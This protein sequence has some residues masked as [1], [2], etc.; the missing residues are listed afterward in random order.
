MLGGFE[1]GI[2]NA[3]EGRMCAPVFQGSGKIIMRVGDIIL[4][5]VA[6]YSKVL[7]EEGDYGSI[8]AASN[9]WDIVCKVAVMVGSTSNIPCLN[10]MLCPCLLLF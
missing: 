3:L 5:I 10:S 7:W 8:M 2:F 4:V 1:L 6:R 9:A